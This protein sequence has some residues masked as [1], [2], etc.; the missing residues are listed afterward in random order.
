MSE[1]TRVNFSP[2]STSASLEGSVIRGERDEYLLGAQAGQQM[3]VRISS[4]ED[5]AVFQIFEPGGNRPL[6]GAGEGDDARG[7]SG[8]LPTS[9]D[10][11]IVVGAT[12]G[13]ANLRARSDDHIGIPLPP[14]YL[15]TRTPRP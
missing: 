14:R 2:G 4:L 6:A 9:G 10:Y 11:R 13:N 1:P 8:E 7:W 15:T 5:N 3:T 12:R